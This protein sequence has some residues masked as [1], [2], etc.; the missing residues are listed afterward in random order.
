MSITMSL[1]QE[2][3]NLNNA[4]VI[5]LLEGNDASA[6]ES[7]TR[8]M[9]LMKEEISKRPANV[10]TASS[11]PREGTETVEIP[12]MESSDTIIFNQAVRFPTDFTL[13]NDVDLIIY[14]SC[15]IFNL[16]LSHHFKASCCGHDIST[17]KAEKLY[18]MVLKL[19]DDSTLTVHTA[20]VVKLACI[21]NLSQIRHS[22]GDY[23]HAREALSQVS[24]FMNQSSNRAMFDEPEIQGLLMNVLLLKEPM[25]AKA[26]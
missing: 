11:T 13:P 5:S 15:V 23:K 16:A 14:I 12:R 21:N 3:A 25:A 17:V 19:L 26:A 9:Q 22:Q 18:G 8:A 7:M 2:A 24:Y 10:R 4:G 20:L 6:I 1:F